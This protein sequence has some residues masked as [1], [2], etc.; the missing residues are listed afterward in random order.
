MI[1]EAIDLGICKVIPQP[2]EKFE[3]VQP[4]SN[5]LSFESKSDHQPIKELIIE[6]ETYYSDLY[7][8]DNFLLGL[9]EVFHFYAG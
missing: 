4:I 5:Q 2:E 9:K 7:Q 3:E 1:E 8:D 6:P